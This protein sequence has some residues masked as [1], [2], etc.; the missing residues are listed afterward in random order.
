[1]LIL[2]NKIDL[3]DERVVAT[4]MGE[5]M[6]QSFGALFAEVS[7][8]SGEGV[9]EVSWLTMARAGLSC[10]AWKESDRSSWFLKLHLLVTCHCN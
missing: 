3:E 8:K 6:A 7:A 9:P 10:G 1:M 2:A 4:S 5:Q